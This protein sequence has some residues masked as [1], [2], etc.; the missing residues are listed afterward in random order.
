[1]QITVKFRMSLPRRFRLAPDPGELRRE[2]DR[3]RGA[4]APWL[5]DRFGKNKMD[6]RHSSGRWLNSRTGFQL[7]DE[8]FTRESFYQDH[9]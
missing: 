6:W 2:L 1:M 8:A 7:P 3:R 9:D 4:V 5:W